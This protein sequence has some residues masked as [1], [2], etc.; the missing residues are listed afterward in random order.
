MLYL[1][2][3]IDGVLRNIYI[4]Q[5]P[6]H[7]SIFLFILPSSSSSSS[8]LPSSTDKDRI[9]DE[10][11][12]DD[13]T[14]A[15]STHSSTRRESD[16]NDDVAFIVRRMARNSKQLPTPHSDITFQQR[17]IERLQ[18]SSRQTLIGSEAIS[19]GALSRV[20]AILRKCIFFGVRSFIERSA[21]LATATSHSRRFSPLLWGSQLPCSH[22]ES[23]TSSWP[24][25]VVA[26]DGLRLAIFALTLPQYSLLQRHC[27]CYSSALPYYLVRPYFIA[28]AIILNQSCLNSSAFCFIPLSPP[29]ATTVKGRM[30]AMSTQLSKDFHALQVAVLAVELVATRNRLLS[31]TTT[32]R[33]DGSVRHL[34]SP[35]LSPKSKGIQ[36]D[37]EMDRLNW[38]SMR[39][40]AC[41]WRMLG[42]SGASW[43]DE[44]M[45]TLS[46]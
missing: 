27:C 43:S 22:L 33:S 34:L 26:L 28:Y 1:D 21:T 9:G 10:G 25:H 2:I 4:G 17:C 6:H 37:S 44:R 31:R 8:L 7:Q 46:L 40:A 39:H 3:G 36:G 5:K 30:V 45:F 16:S 41:D 29:F 13:L 12:R 32:R 38:R 14:T 42:S 19:Y 18:C 11:R 20:L 24:M 35:A 23:R 15:A